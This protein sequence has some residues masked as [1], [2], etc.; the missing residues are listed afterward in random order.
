MY[1]K[2]LMYALVSPETFVIL[3][4]YRLNLSQFYLKFIWTSNYLIKG[5]ISQTVVV[6][7]FWLYYGIFFY[8]GAVDNPV[9]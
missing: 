9:E 1:Y 2:F 8:F 5:I 6:L 7:L 3:L 4:L